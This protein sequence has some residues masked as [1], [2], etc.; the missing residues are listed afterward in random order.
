M[1]TIYGSHS[2]IAPFRLVR[3]TSVTAAAAALAE[4]AGA[5]LAGGVDLVPALRAGRKV[6]R[7]VS[8]DGIDALKAVIRRDGAIG[9]GAG[10]TYHRLSTDPDIAK[11]LPDLAAVWCSVANVRVRHVATI[12]GNIM[13]RNPQYDVLP[14]LQALGARLIFAG[15]G[16]ANEAV[17]AGADRPDGLLSSVEIPLPDERR[18]G[19]DRSMKPVLSV[20]VSLEARGGRIAGRAAIGC[21][22]G[23]PVC[24]ALD[25]GG[26][27]DWRALA[28]R[29]G[30]IAESFVAALPEPDTDWIAGGTYRRTLACVLL[31]RQIKALAER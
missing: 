25:L 8:L 10:V 27:S 19:F 5:C 28:G 20:A 17:E 4:G 24:R 31:S 18:F 9:I 26:I 13:A 12:G 2:A 16:G 23:T 14:A 29:A 22:Y 7:V 15:A 6:D 1:Q 11:A 30:A 3:P 21:A